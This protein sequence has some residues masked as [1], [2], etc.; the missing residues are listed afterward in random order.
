[1]TPEEVE[2]RIDALG[3]RMQGVTDPAVAAALADELL[4][5]MQEGVASLTD[6]E[7]AA[8]ADDIALAFIEI[9]RV[10]AFAAKWNP[11]EVEVREAMAANPLLAEYVVD[12]CLLA[13][14]EMP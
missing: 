12:V 13:G 8:E 7:V 5:L 9:H 1:M 14:I 3:V 11:R 4:E 2:A 10:R 6:E